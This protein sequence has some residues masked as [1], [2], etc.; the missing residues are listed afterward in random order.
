MRHNS[1]MSRA[2]LSKCGAHTLVREQS[3]QKIEGMA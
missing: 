1:G 2:A 3:M